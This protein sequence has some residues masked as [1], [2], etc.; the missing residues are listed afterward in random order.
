MR[1][2]SCNLDGYKKCKVQ[3]PTLIKVRSKVHLFYN[4]KMMIS[5]NLPSEPCEQISKTMWMTNRLNK[6]K[7]TVFNR[8]KML[9]T[10]A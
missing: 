4:S 9:Q 10:L 3:Q 6:I 2:L 8:L 7:I 1:L 5:K